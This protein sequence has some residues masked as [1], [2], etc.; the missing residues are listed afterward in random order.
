MNRMVDDLVGADDGLD[1]LLEEDENLPPTPPEQTFEDTP[2]VHD[3]TFASASLSISDLVDNVRNYKP[4]SP[5]PGAALLSTPM[6]RTVSA[7]STRQPLNLPS[8]P[9]G[10]GN[11]GSIWNPSYNGTPGPSSPA[12]PNSAGF[13]SDYG[14]S[15]V[16]ANGFGHV[17]QSSSNSLLGAEIAPSASRAARPISGGLGSGAAWGNPSTASPSYWSPAYSNGFGGT[18]TGNQKNAN[19]TDISMASPLM[20]SSYQDKANSSWG[21]TPP[22]GQGG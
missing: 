8:V 2:M 9:D 6:G 13:G 7:S 5:A 18:Y 19:I 12:L 4:L 17:R 15:P 20:F 22:N 1:P 10:Q 21:R 14:R 11:N 16:N 3:S